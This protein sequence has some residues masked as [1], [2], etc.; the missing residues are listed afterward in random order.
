MIAQI[1]GVSIP[2]NGIDDRP[3]YQDRI[4][5][6][7]GYLPV[8]HLRLLHH[9]TIRD[10]EDYAGGSTN[11]VSSGHPSSGLWVMIDID[12]FDPRQRAINN[13]PPEFLHY[14][15]LHE[16]GHVVEYTHS[17]MRYVRQRDSA[18]YHAMM[19]HPHRGGGPGGDTEHWADTY[20][21]YFFYTE[22]E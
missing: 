16:M 6:T 5:Y 15:L 2:I 10:R 20:A 1:R 13:R 18:G 9:V 12:S 17:A 11:Y 3:E 21:D 8:E 22:V 19:A 4:I 14:T 7:L